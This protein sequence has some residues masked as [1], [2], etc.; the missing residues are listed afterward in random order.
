VRHCILYL[1]LLA[2]YFTGCQSVEIIKPVL[3]SQNFQSTEDIYYKIISLPPGQEKKLGELLNNILVDN[4]YFISDSIET[5]SFN[6]WKAN[7]EINA[8][9]LNKLQTEI[10]PFKIVNEWF[11][12]ED[13]LQYFQVSINKK[14]IRTEY[15]VLLKNYKSTLDRISDREGRLLFFQASGSLF[16]ALEENRIL[17]NEVFESDLLIKEALQQQYGESYLD[18]LGQVKVIFF[19][20]KDYDFQIIDSLT[21]IGQMNFSVTLNPEFYYSEKNGRFSI[22]P[23]ET[24]RINGQKLFINIQPEPISERTDHIS[25]SINRKISEMSNLSVIHFLVPVVTQKEIWTLLQISDF[26]AAGNIIDKITEISLEETLK[27]SGFKVYRA[28]EK[29]EKPDTGFSRIIRGNAEIISFCK[30][31]FYNIKVKGS[32]SLFNKDSND[33]LWSLT[34]EKSAIGYSAEQAVTTAF[35][36]LGRVFARRLI[37]A[38]P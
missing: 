11:S 2:L 10:L 28:D 31:D 38:F 12:H 18:I 32:L 20:N 14:M 24:V 3:I 26:D 30:S 36:Q 34:L 1:L 6:D 7:L 17:Y 8:L 16:E 23:D 35:S 37:E 9:N 4:H 13:N 15:G 33:D 29:W 21:T 19:D 22:F 27:E 5:E 25:N